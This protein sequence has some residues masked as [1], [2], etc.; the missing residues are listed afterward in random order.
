MSG[1]EQFPAARI[2][3]VDD[4]RT[5]RTK[6]LHAVQALGYTAE[7]ADSGATALARMKEQRFD[8]ILLDILCLLYTSPSPRDS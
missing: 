2:L 3:I 7:T 5:H 1:D 4:Q 6:T 8:L